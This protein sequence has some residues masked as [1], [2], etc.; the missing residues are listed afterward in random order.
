VIDGVN[1]LIIP[2]DNPDALAGAIKRLY[3]DSALCAR[4]GAAGRERVVQHFTWDHFRR[5]LLEAYD[6]ALSS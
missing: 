2:P 6:L 3:D 4:L 1:G 5:R